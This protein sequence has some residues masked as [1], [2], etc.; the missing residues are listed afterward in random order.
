MEETNSNT[1]RRKVAQRPSGRSQRF[2]RA[3]RLGRMLTNGVAH[4]SYNDLAATLGVSR[5]TLYRDLSLLRE[6]GI[7]SPQALQRRGVCREPTRELLERILTTDDAAALLVLLARGRRPI[8]G[9]EYDRVL[10]EARGKVVVALRQA[11][12]HIKDKVDAAVDSFED[13][14]ATS[15]LQD[16]DSPC[17][18]KSY[19]LS[20]EAIG[21]TP[22]PCRAKAA[23]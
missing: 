16:A 22:L 3:L 7:E 10:W 1:A 14:A 20:A 6:A 8:P 23:R 2:A 4:L 12:C 21:F 17:A 15:G 13:Q 5:R 19:H 18:A 9:S 11:S